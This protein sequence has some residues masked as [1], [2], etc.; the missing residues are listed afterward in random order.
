MTGEEETPNPARLHRG[1]KARGAV[2]H[3]GFSCASSDPSASSAVQILSS[4]LR[5]RSTNCLPI[6]SP[7]HGQNVRN[8]LQCAGSHHITSHH[9]TSQA[10]SAC[11]A[12]LAVPK[13]PDPSCLCLVSRGHAHQLVGTVTILCITTVAAILIEVLGSGAAPDACFRYLTPWS[14]VSINC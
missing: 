9:I 12:I 14:R 1:C 11:R 4:H 3:H 5:A 10:Y 8:V 2:G 7:L 13:Y 6:H